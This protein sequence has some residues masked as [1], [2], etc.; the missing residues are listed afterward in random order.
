MNQKKI[1]HKK[2]KIE[3]HFYAV[4]NY[5]SIMTTN[6][7]FIDAGLV[8]ATKNGLFSQRVEMEMVECEEAYKQLILGQESKFR[9]VILN[10]AF[11]GE[12]ELKDVVVEI[13]NDLIFSMDI[14][15]RVVQIYS[16]LAATKKMNQLISELQK[17]QKK[18]PKDKP[19]MHVLINS[20]KG[21]DTKK[22]LISNPKLDITLNYNDDLAAV[23]QTILSSLSK[24]N[25]KG[26][27]LLHGIPGTGKTSYVRF[28]ISKLKHKKDIIFLPPRLANSLTN[29]DLIK[30]LISNPNSIFVIEDA[31]QLVLDRER[32]EVSP[33]SAI[34]NL[35]DGLLSDCLNIQIIC[36]FNTELTKVDKALLRKGRL[37]ARYEFKPLATEKA[38]KLSDKL[39]FTKEINE[40]MTL[41]EIYNQHETDFHQVESKSRIGFVA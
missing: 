26:L 12:F 14:H 20:M 23:H 15:L 13:Q 8:F 17:F 39:G 36:S 21:L 27:V 7:A 9:Q 25:N 31:E 24:R 16:S 40:P 19:E 4:S 35:T 29:P 30:V 10:K 28:I 3:D 33:V 37:I 18:R 32:N 11:N 6:A 1:L 41:A 34:L 22:M 2:D 38:Q 5:A